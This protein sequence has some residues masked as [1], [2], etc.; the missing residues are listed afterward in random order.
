MAQLGSAVSRLLL[1]S[2]SGVLPA[3]RRRSISG[4]LRAWLCSSVLFDVLLRT[5]RRLLLS[6]LLLSS[7]LGRVRLVRI[8]SCGRSFNSQ[9]HREER[10]SIAR[11]AVATA[12]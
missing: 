7:A 10:H 6:G 9:T 1:R 11:P 8:L 3:T 2:A 5:R 12:G 4:L